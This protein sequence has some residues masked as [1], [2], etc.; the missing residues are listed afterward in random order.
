MRN[1]LAALG[2]MALAALV[3]VAVAVASLIAIS[4][5]QWPAF[6]SSTNCTR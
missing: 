5:V 6:P 4:G 2:Q 3:A 1:A